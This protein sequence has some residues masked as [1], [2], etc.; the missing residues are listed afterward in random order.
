MVE[1]DLDKK[2]NN[3]FLG[4]VVRKDLTKILGKSENVP[5]YVIEYLL[6]QYCASDEE[7]VIKE[8]MKKVKLILSENY[9]RPDESEKIK[10]KIKEIGYYTII[11]KI[12]VKLNEKRDLYEAEFSNLG[13][14]GVEVDSESVTK[15]EKLLCGGIWCILKL[16]YSTDSSKSPFIIESLKPI[17]IAKMDIS[18]IINSRK[19]FSKDEW[20]D[21]LLRTVGIEPTILSNK[22]KFHF[23]ERLVP[24]IENN[25]NLVELGPRSTG[26][27]HIYKEISPNSILISGGQTTVANLFYNMTTRKIGLVGLWDV[28]AFDEVAGIS[29]KDK[30]GIQILKDYMASGSFARGKEQKNANA[31]IVLVG[32]INQSVASILKSSHLFQPFPE[33]M[34]NDSAFFDRIHYYLP[35]WEIPKFKPE[36]FTDS[37][38]FIVDYFAEFLREMR[39]RNYT[40]SLQK[41]F[42]LG[43]NLNQRDTIAVT[44]TFS[45]LMKLIYPDQN[46]T[47]EEIQE[48]MEYSL[49]GRR[50]VKEQL[51]RIGGME[52]FDVNFSYIDKEDMKE[53]FVTLTESGGGKLI[54]EGLLNPGQV[55]TV[56]HTEDDKIGVYKLELQVSNGSS[57][58]EKTGLGTNS[59]AKESINTSI[60]FFKANAKIISQSINPKEKDFF[61]HVQD[62]KGVGITK[63]LGLANYISLCSGSLS[64]PVQEQLVV[65]GNMTI[66]GS[67]TPIDNLANLLQVCLEAGAKK[68]LIPMSSASKISTVPPELFSK[69]QISFYSDPNDAV[70]KALGFN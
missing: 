65:L 27:S 3:I 62:L 16:S 44:K 4:K 21:L 50:R 42:K 59:K 51:K 30:D 40:D 60:N 12:T 34:N 8:G 46:A 1:I 43:N 6:G 17:Q 36:H 20:I 56:G 66:G 54:P 28:V 69:F 24:L 39:K 5:I 48:I 52:F 25:Y 38:G 26:K 11:D 57:K 47:K 19:E 13:L 29:F 14:K 55:F 70:Y 61:L 45:G 33:A 32:N 64:K 9:V 53:H 10:S 2:L 18:E 22:V 35:G 63:D 67:I 68:V 15:Y 31:S 58:F 49:E 23:L 41:Y 7:N 37:Y